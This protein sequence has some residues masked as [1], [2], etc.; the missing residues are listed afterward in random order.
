M[1]TEDELYYSINY[2][3]LIKEFY[4]LFLGKKGRAV[5]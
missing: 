4:N 2:M 3:K 5:F 1:P